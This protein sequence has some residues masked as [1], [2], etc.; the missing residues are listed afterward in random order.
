MTFIMSDSTCTIKKYYLQTTKSGFCTHLRIPGCFRQV[1]K[2]LTHLSVK[3]PNSVPVQCQWTLLS[4]K[5][6]NKAHH[7]CQYRTAERNL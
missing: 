6:L 7:F 4:F 1:D 5:N 3:D 2:H